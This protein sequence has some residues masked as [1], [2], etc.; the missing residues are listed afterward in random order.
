MPARAAHVGGRG[1]AAVGQG[2]ADGG[3]GGLLQ[4]MMPVGRWDGVHHA[5]ARVQADVLVGI[6]ER[7]A[8]LLGAGERL[9]GWGGV[10][11]AAFPTCMDS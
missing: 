10:S 7:L 2:A 4:R 5:L 11:I 6:L 9:S 8:V 1:S 3:V